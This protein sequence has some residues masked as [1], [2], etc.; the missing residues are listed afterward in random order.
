MVTLRFA[1]EFLIFPD[2]AFIAV[3]LT[4]FFLNSPARA[5][6]AVR[7]TNS[8]RFSIGCTDWTF[9]ATLLALLR[10]ISSHRAFR[11][12]YIAQSFSIVPLFS[13]CTL[14]TSFRG[15]T[16]LFAFNAAHS[17]YRMFPLVTCFA[18]TLSRQRL[19][20]PTRTI[21]TFPSNVSLSIHVFSWIAS[22]TFS[23]LP[24]CSFWAYCTWFLIV[25]TLPSFQT[26][27]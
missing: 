5:L 22:V 15:I 21:V 11:R 27:C 7:L 17:I 23:V 1:C 26:C 6:D 18:F 12:F 13:R 4:R 19:I 3:F 2:Q 24:V 25:G 20:L 16:S 14:A 10:L 8:P 9:K